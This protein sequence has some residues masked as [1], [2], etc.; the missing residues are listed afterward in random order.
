MSE[1]NQAIE[2]EQFDTILKNVRIPP[3]PEILMELWEE[4]KKPEP[5]LQAIGEM[6]SRDISLSAAVLKTINSPFYG[7]PNKVE[8]IHQAVRLLGISNIISLVTST[9]LRIKLPTDMIR[10][11]ET[12][13]NMTTDVAVSAYLI[14]KRLSIMQPDELYSLGLFQDCG[15][16]LMAQKYSDYGRVF[17]AGM[18]SVDRGM[19]S[20]EEDH[21]DTNHAVL[22]YYLCK[23]W[24]MSERVCCVVR[25]HHNIENYLPASTDGEINSMI[26]TLKLAEH[27]CFNFHSLNTH[28]EW[29]FIKNPTLDY[30]GI[31][32]TEYSDLKEDVYAMLSNDSE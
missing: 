21:Y 11:L 1:N 10:G 4:K 24:N 27:L 16:P 7:L 32:T 3:R 22:G 23:S 31:N 9:A 8:S 5:S 13:W 20:I 19:T 30:L 6:I 17:R 12:F 25:D 28:Y 26:A 2:Q 29:E 18:N 15:A 14:G